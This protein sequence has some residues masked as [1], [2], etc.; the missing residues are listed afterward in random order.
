MVGEV[1]VAAA[2]MVRVTAVSMALA[3]RRRRICAAQRSSP[4]PLRDSFSDPHRRHLNSHC[5]SVN[6]RAWR[7]CMQVIASALNRAA[8][9]VRSL[10]RF[11][12]NDKLAS[13]P[14]PL[15]AR[16]R[17]SGCSYASSLTYWIRTLCCSV[18]AVRLLCTRFRVDPLGV[19]GLLHDSTEAAGADLGSDLNEPGGNPSA[20]NNGGGVGFNTN[21][22]YAPQPSA[23]S[24]DG[25]MLIINGESIRP[26]DQRL[27]Q[28]YYHYYFSQKPL[29]PRLPPP[30]INW[31]N[32]HPRHQQ[33]LHGHS[34]APGQFV[35]Y[36]QFDTQHSML[37]QNAAPPL[38]VADSPQLGSTS[39]SALL[40]PTAADLTALSSL[41]ALQ[42]AE[43]DVQGSATNGPGVNGG[44][45]RG[46][47][48]A[49]LLS[50]DPLAAAASVSP[51]SSEAE[52]LESRLAGMSLAT[53]A[54]DG[55]SGSSALSAQ[56]ASHAFNQ[57]MQQQQQQSLQSQPQSH[58][59]PQANIYAPNA[60]YNP[61]PLGS[62]VDPN[63]FN[64]P[65]ALAA[66]AFFSQQ[67]QN[68]AYGA[69]YRQSPPCTR[70]CFF[71]SSLS[72]RV[73]SHS[74]V[75]F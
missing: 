43:S 38:Q 25:G 34:G 48:A 52:A 73:E 20:G 62:A 21:P 45:L 57:Q 67:Q 32:W 2:A 1:A 23:A 68:Q 10:P 16:H 69:A 30:L 44:S 51:G 71:L 15:G 6:T 56:L 4:A 13:S 12:T 9:G 65:A 46:D 53:T 35:H 29:D 36:Q 11:D 37:A 50:A 58:L 22:A 49:P 26:D 31:S 42:D 55:S 66:A 74:H 27:S 41:D 33:Q 3:E 64:N 47:S 72:H 40:G 75:L 63:A 14:Q 24:G 59:F 19:Q 39:S 18:C 5:R 60:Y 17:Q 28:E 54:S 70:R 61:A 8:G 7:T